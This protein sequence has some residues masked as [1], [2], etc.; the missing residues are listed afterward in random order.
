MND[1]GQFWSGIRIL[2]GDNAGPQTEFSKRHNNT[3]RVFGMYLLARSCRFLPSNGEEG[4]G[5]MEHVVGIS[6]GPN[7]SHA[8][9][10]LEVDESD[11]RCRTC[12]RAKGSTNQCSQL[13]LR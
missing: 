10:P 2:R 13:V 7:E 11:G 12:C 4:T 9:R 6:I 1:V 8:R 3:S 5:P